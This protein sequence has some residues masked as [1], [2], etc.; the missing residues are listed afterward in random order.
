LEPPD[1]AIQAVFR[2]FEAL[3][4]T[5]LEHSAPPDDLIHPLMGQA[6]HLRY[7]AR[8]VTV[9]VASSQH[10]GARLLSN[11]KIIRAELGSRLDFFRDAS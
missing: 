9:S 7:D 11:S 8:R 6:S 2:G 1:A 4:V 3:H 10:C 5:R